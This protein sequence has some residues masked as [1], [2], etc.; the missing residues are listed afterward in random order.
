[1]A[2][3]VIARY[4]S[5]G[6]GSAAHFVAAAGTGATGLLAASL[7]HFR[8]LSITDVKS[9]LRAAGYPVRLP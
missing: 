4:T 2:A 5:G 1:M 6:A 9:E 7:F 8:E 3:T